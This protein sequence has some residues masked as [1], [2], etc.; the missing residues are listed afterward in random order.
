MLLAGVIVAIL[1][2]LVLDFHRLLLLSIL[3][4]ALL[5]CGYLIR[6]LQMGRATATRI[7]DDFAAH[8][9]L[10]HTTKDLAVLYDTALI[11]SSKLGLSEVLERLTARV[12]RS[13]N[14]PICTIYLREGEEFILR[15]AFGTSE[16]QLS[17]V[18][19]G[20]SLVGSA[21]ALRQPYIV[22]DLQ[23]DPL[24]SSPEDHHQW[25]LKEELSSALVV[26]L[27]LEDEVIGT[28]NVYARQ[29]RKF[30]DR[31]LQALDTFARQA[32]IAIE[33]D[34]L[35]KSAQRRTLELSKLLEI[36]QSLSSTLDYHTIISAILDHLNDLVPYDRCTF[37]FLDPASDDLI[38]I[39]FHDPYLEKVPQFR[40]KVGQGIVGKVAQRGQA[41]IVNHAEQDV[42]FLPVPGSPLE[43]QSHLCVPL[44][45]HG[46]VEGVICLIRLEASPFSADDL[47]LAS[48]VAAQVAGGL[49]SA[50]IHEEI[51]QQA[52][53]DSLTQAYSH[54]YLRHSLEQELER[55]RATGIALSY[56]MLDVDHFKT[57][58]D[59]YGHIIGDHV[60][61]AIVE[62]IRQNI[63]QADILGRYGG[64]EFGLILPGTRQEGAA[65]VA[66]RIRRA[67]EAL[68][69]PDSKG[70]PTVRVT[71]SLGIATFPTTADT[72]VE[73]ID[74][75][76]QALYASKRLGGNALS[77]APGTIA[78][79]TPEEPPD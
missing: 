18:S 13:L 23:Q 17:P 8:A 40:I 50:K 47:R 53:R 21:A 52:I 2:F 68:S 78:T 64:E 57:I 29:R 24:A 49:E 61:Q 3:F 30:S 31:E 65:I 33:N 77:F 36:A 63:R 9:L 56:I 43:P 32:V 19:F 72:Y 25:A 4:L 14:V 28:I 73:L 46:R 38:P 51:R 27:L 22:A 42:R 41:E 37:F 12:A 26:P 1:P 71:V 75:A 44:T 45:L 39:A 76:D 54:E 67:V 66:E 62:A 60:L 35:F 58:N 16:L 55:C 15:A 6:D 34:R 70:N 5:A 59:T 69:L 7:A 10:N 11:A 79:D 74:K 20:H 48:I